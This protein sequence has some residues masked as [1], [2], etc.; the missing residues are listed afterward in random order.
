MRKRFVRLGAAALG[1]ALWASAATAQEKAPEKAPD[2]AAPAALC[3]DCH[4]AQ[5]ASFP[6]SP[7]SRIAA[8]ATVAT[9]PSN[10]LCESCHGDG[11]AHIESAG[12]TP[13][14]QTMKG[15]AGA[16]TC[17]TCHKE[18]KQN[19][20][21]TMGVHAAS[22]VVNCTSCHSVHASDP[23]AIPLLKKPQTELC[24]S[25]HPTQK[26]AFRDKPF[27]HRLGRG[28]MECAS[29]HDPHG[30]PGDDMLK[31]TSA[32][33][34]PCLS[35]HAEKRGPFVYPHVEG[36]N[37]D[38]RTCHEPHGSSNPKRLVRARV[39]SLC[40][41]CHS[42]LTP[43]LLGSQPPAIHDLTLPRWRNCTTCHVAVHG[44]HR[45]PK[46]FK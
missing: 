7:H 15:R 33:E 23:K 4:E 11:T 8:K 13:I 22:D 44:S 3:G 1:L 41:E 39:D 40:L 30:R 38:C 27:A 12:E 21:F 42:A 2:K 19:R 45:S 26:A 35:C 9:T 34:L 14:V 25:C 5:A 29:C 20:S 31:K 16:A 43:A 6:K 32:H 10:V 37:G 28:G 18:G 36:V 17:V 24:G 46:L